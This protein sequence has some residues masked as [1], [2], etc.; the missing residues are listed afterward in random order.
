MSTT[1]DPS[2]TTMVEETTGCPPGTEGCPCD[3][4][5]TCEGELVCADGTC[6]AQ[7]ACDQP[8]AEPNDSLEEAIDLGEVVCSMEYA[9]TE[10]ALDGL[11]ADFYRMVRGE[12]GFCLDPNA[13]AL[14]MADQDVRVCVYMECGDETG[15]VFCGGEQEDDTFD[16]LNGCCATNEA[17]VLGGSCPGF[18]IPPEPSAFFIRVSSA[19]E[20][21][22]IPYEL[23]YRFD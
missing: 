17:Q 9:T 7:G 6:E 10:G 12:G 8:D 1:V 14:V 15:D 11:D 3:V 22:C 16:G 20:M 19:D 5:S 13:Q 2:E 21:A 18:P 4:G 23:S